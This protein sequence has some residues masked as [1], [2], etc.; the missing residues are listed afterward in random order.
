MKITKLKIRNLFGIESFDSDGKDI[1]LTG[2]KGAGKTSVIDAIKFALTNK[3][4]RE[5][6]ITQ[7]AKEGEVLIETDNGLRVNR[8][9]RTEKADYKSIRQGE[10]KDEKT[11]S[12][13][14]E[15]FTELQLNPVEFA[16]MDSKE[17]NRIIL[18]L[19]EFKWDMKWIQEQFGEI[20][21][22]TNY[23]QNILCV[24]NDIQSEEGFYFKKRQDI[25][26]EARNKQAFIEEIGASLPTEYNAAH[27]Q[28]VNLGE[29]YKKIETIRS[30]N[31][32]I[33]KAKRAV[34]GRDNK[35]RS[36]EAEYEIAKNAIDRE[37]ASTRNSLEKQ[38][39]EMQARIKAMQ[40]D[41]ETLEEKKI[42]RL[43]IEKKTYQGKIA[44]LDGEIK[45]YS[46][47][48]KKDITS[49]ADLQS[50]AENAEKMKAF[51]NE[52]NRM[53]DLQKDVE[54]LNKKSDDLT[55]KIE[56]ARSLPGEI[57]QN[58]NIPITGLEIKDGVP[59]INGK[60]VSN[61]SEGEKLSLCV[62]VAI[63]REGS[64]KMILIDGIE[65]LDT[66]SRNNMYKM[67]KEKG[68]QFVSTR[69]TDE[70]KL[71]VIEL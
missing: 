68:V 38:I 56:K 46:D 10:E 42:S 60:P 23:D 57:L 29:I 64:L 48:A 11:E 47:L 45:Q 40:K 32:W 31:E 24:L 62:E 7:G 37:T 1:E 35:A 44:E 25:N 8:K 61:L 49:F 54:D 22:E 6:I 66:A 15:I 9:V 39:A 43:E 14:R 12:F 67:L 5:Y 36:F 69:V 51:V 50:E 30:E 21:P 63:Q 55:S 17:Q 52:Y 33:E 58:A 19:I 3:S 26:R 13:L 28:A 59:L 65:K 4:D 18:D 20:P 41:L 71:T 34:S 27:W 53:V 16:A 70:D 2:K